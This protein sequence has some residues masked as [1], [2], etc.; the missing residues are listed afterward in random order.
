MSWLLLVVKYF[1]LVIQSV[2]AIQSAMAGASGQSKKAVFMAAVQA[3]ATVGETIPDAHIAGISKMVDT[4][5]AALHATNFAGFGTSAVPVA[6]PVA[7]QVV[8]Q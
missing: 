8:N 5:V 3:G 4:T 6:A 7:G 2:V 1:P